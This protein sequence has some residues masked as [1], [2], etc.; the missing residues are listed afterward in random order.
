MLNF[1]LLQVLFQLQDPLISCCRCLLQMLH[2]LLCR[3]PAASDL[4]NLH[5]QMNNY[6]HD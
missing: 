4:L 3:L 5:A 6:T 1:E 2:M